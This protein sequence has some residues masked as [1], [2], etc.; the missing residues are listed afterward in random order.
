MANNYKGPLDYIDVATR[1]VEFREKFPQGSLQQVSYEFV[2]VNG[3]DWIIYTAAAY[4]SPDDQRPGIGTAWEPIPGPTNFTRDSEVQNA[5]T[6]AWGR[7]MV[8]ALAVDTKKGIASSEEVRNRQVKSSA[9]AKN[10]LAMADALGN[11]IE[12]LRLL[13]S[14]AKTGGATAAT[15]DKIKAIANGLTGSENTDPVNS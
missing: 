12:G 14:E 3:K 1:I 4:R 2:N 10:W 9:T 6:A 7:A 15:L 5:E 13:Y 8:A 11:D